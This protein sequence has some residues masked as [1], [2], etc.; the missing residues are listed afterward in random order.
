M[1]KTDANDKFFFFCFCSGCS[2]ICWLIIVS[3]PF[4]FL[5]SCSTDTKLTL[6][7]CVPEDAVWVLRQSGDA[8]TTGLLPD[9]LEFW[10][11]R[12][13]LRSILAAWC[14]AGAGVNDWL[15]IGELPAEKR[16]KAADIVSPDLISRT[17]KYLGHNLVILDATESH[18]VTFSVL[19]RRYLVLSFRTG[20]VEE[21]L[22]RR[23]KRGIGWAQIFRRFPVSGA[24]QLYWNSANTS[25]LLPP[26]VVSQGWFS[27]LPGDRTTSTPLFFTP[28]RGNIR[29]RETPFPF[30]AAALCPQDVAFL[31]YPARLSAA[32]TPYWSRYFQPWMQEGITGVTLPVNEPVVM[33]PV[34]DSAAMRRLLLK[35]AEQTGIFRDYD[36]QSFRI[37][38]V[39]DAEVARVFGW[40][41]AT[42]LA[43]T[44]VGDWVI[45]AASAGILER[46][47]DYLRVG[48]T[49]RLPHIP[50]NAT[51][52]YWSY[53]IRQ[54]DFPSWLD[55]VVPER[56][57]AVMRVEADR[58]GLAY[59]WIPVEAPNADPATPALL[60]RVSVPEAIKEYYPLY[61]TPF[62]ALVDSLHQL[63]LFEEESGRLRWRVRLDGPLLSD[64]ERVQDPLNGVTGWLMNTRKTVYFLTDD[65]ADQAGFPRELRALAS[66]G[67]TLVQE[68]GRL[69]YFFFPADNGR[70]YGYQLSGAPLAG[71]D[72]G[73]LAGKVE[74]PMRFLAYAQQDYLIGIC[75]DGE[76]FAF[77]ADGQP[78][79]L[80]VGLPVA[81]HPALFMDGA[82][83]VVADGS[84]RV[85]V[86]NLRGEHFPLAVSPGNRGKV[87]FQF[88]DLWGDTRKD[89]LAL[90]GKR[91][92]LS[93]YDRDEFRRVW[94]KELADRP[95]RLEI[96][97][98]VEK[99]G[100]GLLYK[101]SRTFD[102]RDGRGERIRGFPI[103][104]THGL[105]WNAK[106]GIAITVY[107]QALMAYRINPGA[108]R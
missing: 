97:P 94:G 68:P 42:S 72:P 99:A 13:G 58:K 20:L 66:T 22:E 96:V 8:D 102:V 32:A 51:A 5:Y 6:G 71:W 55:S 107:E 34:R 2:P 43:F 33:L 67:L 63:S 1:I 36:Y 60:W 18:K 64:V 17:W 46:W 39:M 59:T 91:L 3:F 95:D 25:A 50:E 54:Q 4:L 52:L 105:K 80:G 49:L 38:H 11:A 37:V 69:P 48:A 108:S 47:I 78:H 90:E 75:S 57:R 56:K 7:R 40:K 12:F 98:G 62:V 87:A 101:A 70:I 27:A 53:D 61:G 44:E 104:S 88:A 23:S 15:L 82:R 24:S 28:Q 103:G 76:L 74:S 79:F 29:G 45:L 89:Y 9:S 65:G 14:P 30:S 16:K 10:R 41:N 83:V 93:A 77:G 92:T 19:D 85:R 21:A 106:Q 100:I 84:S 26:A 35:Y 31:E 73:P 86:A 81:P